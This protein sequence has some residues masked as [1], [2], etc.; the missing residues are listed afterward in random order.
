MTIAKLKFDR[1]IIF[2]YTQKRCFLGQNM[3]TQFIQLELFAT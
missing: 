2:S 1:D 3:A